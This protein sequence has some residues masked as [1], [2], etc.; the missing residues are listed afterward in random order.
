MTSPGP[1]VITSDV[2]VIVVVSNDAAV[3]VGLLVGDGVKDGDGVNV[4]DEV[5]VG[6]GVNVG[7][8]GIG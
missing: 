3:L 5:N 2:G 6:D 1:A 8:G 7:V 4:G